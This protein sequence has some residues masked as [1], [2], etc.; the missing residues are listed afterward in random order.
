ML[1]RLYPDTP[2]YRLL[3]ELI[4]QLRDGAI[5]IYPTA[6]GY[7]YC[8]DALQS[9][10]IEAL[11]HLKGT[12]PKKKALSIACASLSQVSEYCKLNDRAFKFVKEHPENYTYILPASS[13]LPKIFKH[14]KEV[15]V[16]LAAHPI[17]KLLAEHLGNPLVSASLNLDEGDETEYATHPELI[18]E[19]FGRLVAG[20]F[21]A[22]EVALAPSTIVDCTSEPFEILRQGHGRLMDTEPL[23]S[24]AD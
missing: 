1:I 21:D 5:F 2:D 20:V 9:K 22:G 13:E 24:Q 11:C 7:A 10:A 12:D 18:D 15:G 4:A 8:C 3:S 16:R 6:S 19:R 23:L 17:G 14:R